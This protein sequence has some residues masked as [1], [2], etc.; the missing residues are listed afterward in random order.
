MSQVIYLKEGVGNVV[1]TRDHKP[2]PFHEVGS[3]IGGIKLDTE[4]DSEM[5]DELNELIKQKSGGVWLSNDAEYDSKKK[6]PVWRPSNP[7]SEPLKVFQPNRLKPVSDRPE[8][9]A[10]AAEPSIRPGPTLS[11]ALA[12]DLTKPGKP[13]LPPA[14]SGEAPPSAPPVNLKPRVGRASVKP[15]PATE[16]APAAA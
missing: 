15:K 16:I 8:D 11:P 6:L 14:E 7:V 5:I 13:A 12:Q 1:F 3:D 2:I 10:A 9:V 4:R